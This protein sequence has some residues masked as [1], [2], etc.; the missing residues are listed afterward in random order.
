M[1]SRSRSELLPFFDIQREMRFEQ[2]AQTLIVRSYDAARRSP[3]VQKKYSGSF[4]PL[5]LRESELLLAVALRQVGG[6]ELTSRIAGM[7]GY[8][9]NL[10]VLGSHDI[11]VS[12]YGFDLDDWYTL[13][14][15]TTPNPFHQSRFVLGLARA[16]LQA[17][18]L[19]HAAGY[20]HCDVHNG[21][22]CLPFADARLTADGQALECSLNPD[23]LKLIDLGLSL[24]PAAERGL[25]PRLQEPGGG[26]GDILTPH[27][28]AQPP[29]PKRLV[30]ALKRAREGDLAPWLA[31]DWRLD[32]WR[33]GELIDLWCQRAS[34]ADGMT[35]PKPQRALLADLAEALRRPEQAVVAGE[36]APV[37]LPHGELIGEITT[38]IG[39]PEPVRVRL[40]LSPQE[41]TGLSALAPP[42]AP[43]PSPPPPVQPPLQPPYA[44]VTEPPPVR[45]PPSQPPRAPAAASRPQIQKG[46]GRSLPSLFAAVVVVGLV[47]GGA[48]WFSRPQDEAPAPGPAPV[49]VPQPQPAPPTAPAPAAAAAA[50]ATAQAPGQ[51]IEAYAGGPVLISL[52]Q[53]TDNRA[54]TLLG[55]KGSD[56]VHEQPS[57]RVRVPYRLA[58]GETEVTFAQWDACVAD[59]DCSEQPKDEWGRDSQPVMNIRWTDIEKYLQ[60]LN[61]KA[62]IAKDSP[63]RY[64]LPT[65]AEWEYAARAGSNGEFSLGRGNNL[66]LSP[67]TAN[68]NGNY[69]Y[70][71]SPKGE[72]R[73]GTVQVK[74]FQPNAWGLYDMHGNVWEWVQD[75][76][77][78]KEYSR[79]EGG[80]GWLARQTSEEKDKCDRV[81]RG[82]SWNNYPRNLRSAYRVRGAPGYRG[83]DVGFRL[84]RTLP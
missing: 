77:N 33:L 2:N 38:L 4:S 45:P 80:Q 34:D 41:A 75:C 42:P 40:A 30:A 83:N 6:V 59:K 53:A 39:A 43:L 5:Q 29:H 36:P 78:E 71:G 12:W 49:A 8:A 11:G 15:G 31:L 66:A 25:P 19:L 23:T 48:W 60:W 51:R 79:R 55:Q 32:L 67:A 84:A 3:V 56:Y 81:L 82:G 47:G 20:V 54:G 76:Y 63:H 18:H 50:E 73:A 22:W 17:L 35:G 64:R 61:T 7:R 52:P 58:M 21:N 44:P 9:K 26:V 37:V 24:K 16:A 72:Y 10:S 57:Y 14:A 69:Q 13:L 28:H 1:T 65:E 70:K 46:S 74:T 27:P 68:Y 62:G